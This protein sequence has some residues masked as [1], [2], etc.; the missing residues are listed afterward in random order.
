MTHCVF[1]CYCAGGLWLPEMVDLAGG[2]SGAQEP[3]A[4]AQAITW[5]QVRTCAVV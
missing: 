5:D 4:P 3:G 1:S 2:C